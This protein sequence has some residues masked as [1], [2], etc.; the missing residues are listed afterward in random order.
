MNKDDTLS[1][2]LQ[3]S[4]VVVPD[5]TVSS[6]RRNLKETVPKT[7][8]EI[9]FRNSIPNWSE[10]LKHRDFDTY[11]KLSTVFKD[12]SNGDVNIKIGNCAFKC[13]KMILRAY[14]NFFKDRPSVTTLELPDDIISP[15]AF[16][17][18]YYWMVDKS[19]KIECDGVMEVIK[20]AIYFEVP[21]LIE[22]CWKIFSNEEYF[23]EDVAFFAFFQAR[24][25]DFPELKEVMLKRVRK[26]YL[27]LTCT[28]EFL[29]LTVEE[30]K[31]LISSNYIEVNM[32]SE[33][34]FSVVRW[35]DH[36]WEERS[37]YLVSLM[38]CVRFTI[39]PPSFLLYLSRGGDCEEVRKIVQNEDVDVII[40]RA[41]EFFAATESCPVSELRLLLVH[42]NLPYRP[43]NWIFDPLCNYHHRSD[44]TKKKELTY[45]TYLSYLERLQNAS[46]NYW[47][48]YIDANDP[49]A[50]CCYKKKHHN[51]E[52]ETTTSTNINWSDLNSDNDDFTTM[53]TSS[54]DGTSGKTGTSALRND[55][56]LNR[57]NSL[58]NEQSS[59]SS[60]KS[61]TKCR[62]R[63]YH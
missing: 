28:A 62:G 13:H 33:V 29:F 20:A 49:R 41:L 7:L 22:T 38:Q 42:L 34:F 53:A 37:I 43:R 21:L 55:R 47:N 57:S 36:C 18:L 39:M 52:N 58:S 9:G 23:T 25:Y 32:E 11:D 4:L 61:S 31:F 8:H 54:T 19:R 2:C 63:R 27:H 51:S 30:L 56:K 59:S 6:T 44:C 5:S 10:T 50:R 40:K 46:P 45:C 14:S 60:S 16:Q 17:V 48:T 1:S 35:L 26:F 15:G 12:T 24:S 3:E